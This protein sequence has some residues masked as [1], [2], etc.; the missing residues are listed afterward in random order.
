LSEHPSVGLIRE[1]YEARARNDVAAIRSI[2]DE[3]VVWHEPEWEAEHTGDLRG[4][5][6]VL[7][8]IGEARRITDGTFSLVPRQIVANGEHAVALIDW[9][10]TRGEARGWR[11]RRSPSIACA[12]AR[13]WRLLFTRTTRI[14]TGSSG[15]KHKKSGRRASNPRPPAWEAGALPTELRPREGVF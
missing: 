13:S 3:N 6:A 9:S 5:E 15:S 2:L 8:M 7:A 14:R 4:S 11:G 12:T 10:A 1:L